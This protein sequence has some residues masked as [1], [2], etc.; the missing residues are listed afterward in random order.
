MRRVKFVV[1]FVCSV[2]TIHAQDIIYKTNGDSIVA[3]VL[4]TNRKNLEYASFEQGAAYVQSIPLK[5]VSAISYENAPTNSFTV[6]NIRI[7][8][9]PYAPANTLLTRKGNHYYYNGVKMNQREYADFLAMNSQ[10][11]YQR[12]KDGYRMSNYG[13]AL[14]G[15][16]CAI[17]IIAS[18]LLY[19][20]EPSFY[21]GIDMDIEAHSDDWVHIDVEPKNIG[22]DYDFGRFYNRHYSY[23]YS[24]LS[25]GLFFIG[26]ILQI[27][28]IPIISIGYS[29]MHRSVDIY[30]VEK[31]KKYQPSLSVKGGANGIGVALNF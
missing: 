29:D 5:E 22:Y 30:N 28:S 20:R 4:G 14:L 19:M 7:Q 9:K 17:N 13:W 11:A 31:V 18:S 1:L 6:P 2:L 25:H 10:P 3:K 24:G 12:F 8:E 15:A 26:S 27:A 16:G 23:R 21:V